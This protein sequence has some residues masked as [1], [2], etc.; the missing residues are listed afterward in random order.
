MRR[1]RITTPGLIG[2][3]DLED[4]TIADDQRV[5]LKDQA[6]RFNGNDPAGG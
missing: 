3:E 6:I 2:W 5:L 1:I 4:A